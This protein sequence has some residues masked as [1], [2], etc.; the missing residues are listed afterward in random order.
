MNWKQI[1]EPDSGTL[2]NIV[3]PD[4]Q[5]SD[6]QRLVTRL[7]RTYSIKYSEDGVERPIPDVNSIF[8]ARLQRTVL[9]KIVV[10]PKVALHCHFFM[11]GEIELDL[12]PDDINTEE[13]A[14][15]VLKAMTETSKCL[16]KEVFLMPE[17]CVSPNNE[18]REMAICTAGPGEQIKSRL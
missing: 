17:G 8:N 16:G 12:L 3:V 7:G 13:K 14:G 4:V 5:S 10:M 1:F 18:L 6:W 15:A 9:L 11:K 2:L